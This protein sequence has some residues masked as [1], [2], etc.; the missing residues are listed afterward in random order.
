M[1]IDVLGDVWHRSKKALTLLLR[2]KATT[3]WRKEGSGNKI[4]GEN[5][6]AA[7]N[8]KGYSQIQST[9]REGEGRIWESEARAATPGSPAAT[10]RTAPFPAGSGEFR[11]PSLVGWPPMLECNNTPPPHSTQWQ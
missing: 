10:T 1:R 11:P 9:G 3:N 6:H 8:H 7:Y 5:R 2:S 4:F